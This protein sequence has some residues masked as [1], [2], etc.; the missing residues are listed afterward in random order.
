[1]GHRPSNFKESDV[2]RLL[3]AIAAAGKKVASV[4]IEDGRIKIT[5]KN[6]NSAT[7]DD[8]NNDNTNPWDS[9]DLK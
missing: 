3:R 8:N 7:A 2:K 6:S 1:M 4:E 5:I 9:V